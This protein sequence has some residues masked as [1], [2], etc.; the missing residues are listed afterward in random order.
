M[1]REGVV[2][3]KAALGCKSLS[4][5]GQHN[6]VLVPRAPRGGASCVAWCSYV[7]KLDSDFFV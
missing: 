3:T 2:G 6:P 4:P 5:R 1:R 7:L